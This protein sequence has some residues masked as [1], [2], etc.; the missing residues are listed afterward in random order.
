MEK[1]RLRIRPSHMVIGLGVLIAL[2]T[3]AS[4]VTYLIEVSVRHGWYDRS[5]HIQREVFGGIPSPLKLVFY[6]IIPIVLV[7]GAVL[8]AYRVRNWERGQPDRRATTLQN[9]EH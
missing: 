6:V 7:Y 2:L 9:I 8:F 5:S 4:G 3:V 1:R